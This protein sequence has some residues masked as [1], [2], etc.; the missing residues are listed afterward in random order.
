VL[1]IFLCIHI[2]HSGKHCHV[3]RLHNPTGLFFFASVP[4]PSPSSSSS[5]DT[6]RPLS[7][8]ALIMPHRSSKTM[9]HRHLPHSQAL[10]DSDSDIPFQ[11]SH[12]SGNHQERHSEKTGPAHNEAISDVESAPVAI[13][14]GKRQR[15]PT[16]AIATHDAVVAKSKKRRLARAEKGASSGKQAKP[17]KPENPSVSPHSS[18]HR[19]NQSCPLSPVILQDVKRNLH[20]H[21][22]LSRII[23]MVAQTRLS[24]SREQLKG[25]I[26]IPFLT[27]GFNVVMNNTVPSPTMTKVCSGPTAC[28]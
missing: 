22:N 6:D 23:L 19:K 24:Q 10:S 17:C 14:A 3:A 2:W 27:L 7:I 5:C 8:V 1:I 15:R 11:F 20:R 9:Q 25:R 12:R 4:S 16:L 28:I 13:T 18:S 26:R 21:C